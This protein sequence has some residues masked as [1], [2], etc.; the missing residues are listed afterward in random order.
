MARKNV[1]GSADL[2]AEL[3]NDPDE[4]P[5]LTETPDDLELFRGDTFIRRSPG[6]PPTG[7]AKEL[8]S[9]RLSRD[10]VAK[11]R[12]AGPGWQSQVD[13]LLRDALG[14]KLETTTFAEY[15]AGRRTTDS[16][17]GDFIADARRAPT[18]PDA[19]TWSE[20]E[21]Y[22]RARGAPNVAVSAA[23]SVWRQYCAA[24][25]RREKLEEG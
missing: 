7:N 1:S 5:I 22:L 16:P 8:I 12:E 24:N 14:L 4:A 15:V 17:A 18:L 11:L 25:Q 9:V 6:R 2:A 10:V 19:H 23:R 3:A 13:T 20:I 21:T